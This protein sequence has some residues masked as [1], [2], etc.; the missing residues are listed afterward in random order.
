MALNSRHF[1][2]SVAYATALS[3]LLLNE[4]VPSWSYMNYRGEF[5][6]PGLAFA[7]CASAILGLSVPHGKNAR[8]MIVAC[9]NYMFF[10]PSAVYMSFS[11]VTVNYS[12][13]FF[14]CFLGI[15]YISRIRVPIFIISHMEQKGAIFVT[16]SLIFL[17]LLAQ[18][19][20]G[21]LRYFNLNIMRVYEFRG[22]S[23]DEVPS[24]FGYIFSGVSNVLIPV[25]L[26]LSIRFKNYVTAFLVVCGA[27]F[28]FGMT[29]HKTVLFMPFII[30]VIYIC[31]SYYRRTYIIGFV[32]LLISFICIS[33]VVYIRY[34]LDSSK[35]IAY[36]SSYILRRILFTPAMLDSIFVDF[37]SSNVKYYWSSSRFGSWAIESP[38]PVTAPYLIGEKYFSDPA[39]SANTGMIGSGYANA[40]LYGV[41]LYSI[42]VGM[43]ISLL[44]VYGKRIGHATVAAVS[45]V[46]VFYVV[47]TTDL[48][49]AIL[50]HGLLLLLV[51]LAL[52]SGPAQR[53]ADN[54]AQTLALPR[55]AGH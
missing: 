18:S 45:L 51:M 9:L 27:V 30:V 2:L 5:S 54:G 26:I 7:V 21:G 8:A 19:Y 34:I 44:N 17:S 13:A 53:S 50:S 28:L 25:A 4:I 40:G 29:H 24:I 36:I 35:Y 12:I 42:V 14:F 48:T 1:F 49:T 16:V 39:M 37:F 6:G 11:G 38:Y 52:F 43:L 10:V 3:W 31:F 46:S 33:E 32:F 55:P 15:Y 41:F 22:M 47:T 23:A 20:F